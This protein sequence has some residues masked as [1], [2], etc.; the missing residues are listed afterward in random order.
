M[1]KMLDL[2]ED[3]RSAVNLDELWDKL[4]LRLAN[5]GITSIF[6]GLG[7]ST[8]L[9]EEQGIMSSI[10][11]KTSHPEEYRAIF[12]HKYYIDDDLGSLHCIYKTTPFI[13]HD[14]SQWGN[15][16]ERQRKFMLDSFEHDMGVGVSLPVRFNHYGFGGLGL[17][18]A[19]TGEKEFE[20]MWQSKQEEIVTISHMFDELARDEHQADIYHLTPRA[21]STEDDHR[22]RLNMIAFSS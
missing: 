8:R 21:Y 5:F 22:Q 20:K 4:H 16:T 7:G 18:A 15:P 19:E 3:Y 13:W 9:V 6:Y 2:F 14:T 17:C 11:H 12:D 10:W 1:T